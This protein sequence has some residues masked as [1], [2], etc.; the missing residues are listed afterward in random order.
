MTANDLSVRKVTNGASR[1]P[2][3]DSHLSPRPRVQ[4]PLM[5]AISIALSLS[6]ALAAAACAGKNKGAAATTPGGEG[7]DA[8]TPF[9]DASVKAALSSTAGVET[10]GGGAASTTVGDHLAAERAALTGGDATVIV[11]ETFTCRAQADDTWACEWGISAQGS[12]YMILFTVAT[13]GT[14]ARGTIACGAV[15]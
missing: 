10:C 6:L 7:D 11:T 3:A 8:A 2:D 12:A 5:K 14:I 9:D 15:G 1:G 4:S 13:D